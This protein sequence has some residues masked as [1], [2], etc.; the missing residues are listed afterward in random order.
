MLKHLIVAASLLAASPV[1]AQANAE[2]GHAHGAQKGPH[3]GALEDIAGVHA[4]IEVSGKTLT[5]HVLD[6]AGKGV[7]TTGFSGSAMLVLGGARQ[8]LAL[9]PSGETLVGEAPAPIAPGTAV[10]LVLK[11]AAGKSGQAK[12]T[13]H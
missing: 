13:T 11:T 2:S 7:D 5:V 12:F 4:E 9:K 8:T 1:L 6:G 10:T 3:G